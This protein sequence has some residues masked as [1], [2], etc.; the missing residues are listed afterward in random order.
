LCFL[1][2]NFN[3]HAKPGRLRKAGDKID[4]I[5]ESS[6]HEKVEKIKIELE[7]KSVS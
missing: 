5:N 1:D 3:V 7:F 4:V 6:S 2:G